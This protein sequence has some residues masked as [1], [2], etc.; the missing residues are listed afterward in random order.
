MNTS[1][2]IEIIGYILPTNRTISN[3]FFILLLG[4][5]AFWVAAKYA[6][7][8]HKKSKTAKENYRWISMMFALVP[9]LYLLAC[10]IFTL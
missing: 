2:F 10:L 1:S 6:K 3:G 5:F 8:K 9:A 4:M 7:K